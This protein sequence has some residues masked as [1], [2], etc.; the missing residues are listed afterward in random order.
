MEQKSV[1]FKTHSAF[2]SCGQRL[3]RCGSLR[4]SNG[5]EKL[6]LSRLIPVRPDYKTGFLRV[7]PCQFKLQKVAC[8]NEVLSDYFMKFRS[9]EWSFASLRSENQIVKVKFCQF[10]LWMLYRTSVVL[11]GKLFRIKR[12]YDQNLSPLIC[13]ASPSPVNWFTLF[14]RWRFYHLG[15]PYKR[16]AMLPLMPQW[17]HHTWVRVTWIFSTRVY[18]LILHPF[19]LSMS[20]ASLC[21]PLMSNSAWQRSL[22]TTLVLLRISPLDWTYFRLKTATLEIL[23]NDKLPPELSLLAAHRATQLANSETWAW[24]YQF[25][26]GRLNT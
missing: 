4:A 23:I 12:V 25:S 3:N 21:N 26:I 6:A 19:L 14:S 17:S 2:R 16:W 7:N 10:K 5:Q 22:K 18:T 1:F 8:P 20:I 13:C 24:R 11:S 9:R 15:R